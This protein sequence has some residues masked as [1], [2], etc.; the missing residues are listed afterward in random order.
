MVTYVSISTSPAHPRSRGEHVVDVGAVRVGCGSS[1][2]ARG[3]LAL[4]GERVEG[5]RLIPARAG[6]IRSCTRTP[7]GKSAHPRSRGEHLPVFLGVF[8]GVGSSPLARGT[9]HAALTVHGSTRL[10]PAR[11]GN[12]VNRPTTT[13]PNAA[14]PRSRGEHSPSARTTPRR[15]G[16][17]P[18][19]RGT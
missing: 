6:N 15:Y 9:S 16:S 12:M 4:S 7:T 5:S 11:A 19:A 10:I 2:L 13:H 17:S 3:T 1:P 8:L 14:H 18:L